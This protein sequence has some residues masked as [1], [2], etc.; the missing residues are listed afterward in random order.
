MNTLIGTH[1][2]YLL[3]YE[4]GYLFSGM[5]SNY[6]HFCFFK[7][8]MYF[9]FP[10]IPTEKGTNRLGNPKTRLK[11]FSEIYSLFRFIRVQYFVTKDKINKQLNH[12]NVSGNKIFNLIV[13]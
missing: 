6:F 8:F 9:L 1:H 12:L 4:I 11:L 3:K 10:P 2:F 7:R 5:V 13:S